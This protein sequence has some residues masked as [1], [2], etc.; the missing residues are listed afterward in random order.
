M[1]T[2][3]AYRLLDTELRGAYERDR[4]RAMDPAQLI[5]LIEASGLRGR[6]GA[7]FPLARKLATARAA[8][9]GGSAFIVANAYD[10]DPGS[11]LSRTLL[12][13]RPELVIEGL[14]IA[15]AAIGATRAFLYLHP[16]AAAARRAAERALEERRAGLG[17]LRVEIAL[18]PGGFIGG[19]ESALLAVL[20]SRRAMARQRPPYPAIQGLQ[21]RPTVVAS[22]ETLAALPLILRDGADAFRR[23]G[24]S[25][26]P[27]TKLVSVTGAVRSAGVY[28][29]AFGTPL[30]EIIERAGGANGTLK[31]IHV[32]GP[33]GGILNATRTT[34]G[35]D[36][37]PLKAAGTH[38]GSGQIRV[39]TDTTCVVNDAAR[40]F[41]YLARETCAI[42]VPCRVGTKRVQG[43]LEG[44]YSGLGRDDDLPWLGEL[45]DHLSD[46]SLC[47]F[48]I[49]SASIIRTTMSEF[50][51]DYR[52]HIVDR[53]CPAGTCTPARARRYETMAQP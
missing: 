8:A 26:S 47:G 39:L 16:E 40:L 5:A 35:L 23:A 34:V 2:S 28:E 15:A 22:G 3:T 45:A 41:G 17:D 31:G 42:C 48:G 38:L 20:E 29:V 18:G 9:A 30:G 21:L 36:Y 13:R 37:E 4:A 19:E 46:F 11:P 32:G 24:T 49:T 52:R 51:D 27:G 33:T 50:P 25:T 7:G 12:L 14:A 44:I 43:I 10:A 1:P 53:T 6:G